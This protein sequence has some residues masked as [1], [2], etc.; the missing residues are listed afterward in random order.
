MCSPHLA[1]Y[2]L[3]ISP[4]HITS[5]L[6]VYTR[7]FY[8]NF[9]NPPHETIM[10]YMPYLCKETPFLSKELCEDFPWAFS[11]KSFCTNFTLRNTC[12]DLFLRFTLR[13]HMKQL[14][15]RLQ[16]EFTLRLHMNRKLQE[17]FTSTNFTNNS[18]KPITW[19]FPW[20]IMRTADY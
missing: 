19:E 1:P 16:L 12:G 2:H 7:T 18:H 5:T 14:C 6:K 11:R 17:G 15:K 13:L 3:R 9:T 8:E 4:P 10:Q 20:L